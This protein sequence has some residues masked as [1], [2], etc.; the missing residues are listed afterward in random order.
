PP[1]QPYPNQPSTP[2]YPAQPQ[3]CPNQPVTPYPPTQ[4]YPNQPGTP[5]YPAQPQPCPNQPVTPY[6]PTQPY[7]NQPS[8]P[9]YPAQPQPCPNQP[10]TPYPPTQ[11]YPPGQPQPCPNQPV[12]PYPPVEAQPCPDHP[13][14]PYPPTQPNPQP[15][16]NVTPKP[17]PSPSEPVTP[18]SPVE[19]QPNPTEPSTPEDTTLPPDTVE[20][21]PP[22][23][24]TRSEAVPPVEETSSTTPSPDAIETAPEETNEESS[25][26]RT[27]ETTTTTSPAPSPAPILRCTP[28]TVLENGS[29]RLVHCGRGLYSNGRCV[30]PRC[31]KNTVWAGQRCAAPEP[32]ELDPIHIHMETVDKASKVLNNK[33]ELV[34][35]ASLV[36]PQRED[37]YEDD[38]Y[39]EEVTV[40][41]EL[42]SPPCCTV[43][44]PRICRCQGQSNRWQCFN[45]RQPLCGDFCKTSKVVLKAPEATT[46]V[47]DTAEMLLM[48]P[49]PNDPCLNQ[50]NCTT[51]TDRYDCSGCASGVMTSCSFYCYNYRCNGPNCSFYDQQQFCSSPEVSGFSLCRPENG[52]KP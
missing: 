12:T 22:S 9:Y 30:M 38:E 4:P 13:V 5:Y 49:Q 29:C 1:T 3:P 20:T 7:P 15:S 24:T 45:R 48:P 23:T 21:L 51:A 2:Y 26:A 10:V 37:D 6:P 31:P 44:A 46:W 11:P 42:T 14:T 43:I 36:L 41:P 33:H 28:G 39:S 19:S 17:Q 32:V 27:T 47:D 8:T 16:P 35:N 52:W 25:T 34:V 18:S 40:A 50:G